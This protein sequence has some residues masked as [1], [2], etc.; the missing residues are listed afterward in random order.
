M[1]QNS[2]FIEEAAYMEAYCYYM[3]SPR[4]ELDQTSYKPGAG[5]FQALHDQ[6]PEKSQG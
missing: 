4:P 6:V 2:R 1:Y 3:Q 5:C